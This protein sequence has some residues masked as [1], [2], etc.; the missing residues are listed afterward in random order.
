MAKKDYSNFDKKELIEEIKKLEK[1][2]K[3][4]LVWEDKPEKV[5]EMCKEKLPVLEEDKEKEI[6][7]DKEK[8]YNILIEG[9]NYHA[10][11]VLNYTHKGKIDV[12]YID[13]PYNTGNKTWTY[14][15]QYIDEQDAF[16]HSKWISMMAKRLRLAKNLLKDKGILIS[17]IDDYEVHNLRLLLDEIFN[18]NNRLGTC[19]VVHNPGGRQDEKFFPTAHEYMLFYAKN[20]NLAEIGRLEIPDEK[21]QQ[22]TYKDKFGRYKLREFRRSGSNSRRRDGPGLWYPIYYNKDTKELTLEK[23]PGLI[24]IKPIDNK[25]IERCWR[26]G[27]ETFLRNKDKY[28]EVR[29]TKNGEYNLYVKEREEDNKGERAKTIWN[30]PRYSAVNGTNL[31]KNMFNETEKKIFDY[32]KSLFL[33][34]DVLKITAMK[35]DS[36]I[37]DFFAGSGTTGHAVLELNKEDQGKRKV[38]LCTNNEDNRGEGFNIAEKVCYPRLRKAIEGYTNLNGKKI[39]GLGGNLKYFK[40]DFVDAKPTDSNKKKLVNKSTEMLC[41]REDCFNKIKEQDTFR[42]YTNNKG[43][44]LGII[45]NEEGLKPFKKELKKLNK[46]TVVYVFSLDNSAREEEFEDVKNLV[47][48]KPIPEVILNVYRRIFK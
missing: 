4:G 22:Y 5:A 42:V 16:K 14:N 37:L 48:L 18:E 45:Y 40:T 47:D 9:D 41:L 12:I 29:K 30:K 15:N 36:I 46:K 7:T 20:A 11:S 39:N 21:N 32:P 23:K 1:R 28:I 8:D 43:K 19:V 31:I 24:E 13:P 6:V 35:K 38:I 33:M 27:K 10:L 2:K 26:W 3:Y 44:L 25:N 17:A 34:L